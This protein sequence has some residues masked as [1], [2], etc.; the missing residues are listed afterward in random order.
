MRASE[1]G[2]RVVC[3]RIGLVLG[4]GGGPL[5]KMVPFFK[6]GLGGRMGN[7]RQWMPWVHL[8]DVVGAMMFA[9]GRDDVSGAINVVSPAPARNADFAKALARALHR[10]A[11]APAPAFALRIALGEM[12]DVALLAGQRVRPER[13]QAAGFAFAFTDLDAALENLVGPT[14]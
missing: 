10:P 12:A 13:L 4:K 6:L 1:L 11:L 2:V 9:L 3:T 5:A 7:G 14:P 8:R